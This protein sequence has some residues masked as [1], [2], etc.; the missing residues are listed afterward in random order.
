MPPTVE[1][2]GLLFLLPFCA[3]NTPKTEWNAT[4]NDA[5]SDNV[6]PLAAERLSCKIR[7]LPVTAVLYS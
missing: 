4:K 7:G 1:G 2:I 3:H 6:E 5:S